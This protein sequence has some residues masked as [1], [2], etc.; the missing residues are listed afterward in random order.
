MQDILLEKLHEESKIN[1]I[2]RSV[3]SDA[4]EAEVLNFLY[5]RKKEIN[6]FSIFSKDKLNVLSEEMLSLIIC[7]K[8]SVDEFLT[9]EEIIEN[10]LKLKNI[11]ENAFKEEI[12]IEIL[13]TLRNQVSLLESLYIEL[14]G[15]CFRLI[16]DF[17]TVEKFINSLENNKYSIVFD[18]FDFYKIISKYN[19]FFK[20]NILLYEDL[21]NQ[22]NDFFI[23]LSNLLNVSD[24]IVKKSFMKK[25]NTKTKK[26]D[27]YIVR[28]G[29]SYYIVNFLYKTGLINIYFNLRNVDFIKTFAQKILNLLSGVTINEYQ[30]RPFKQEEKEKIFS[31]YKEDN[32]LLN[33]K[34]NLNL[35]KL[36][37]YNYV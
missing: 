15:W 11:L 21:L 22:N 23:T 18:S 24:D 8:D 36:K 13:I 4:R 1:F 2:G 35:E 14:F 28:L 29:L 3:Y 26:G 37:K 31:F 32:L 17:S 33:K 19:E 5:G 10:I 12:E 16:Y 27:K 34:F 20:V 9:I 6:N 25:V 30:V 7:M